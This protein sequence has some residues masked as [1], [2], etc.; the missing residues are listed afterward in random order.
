MD[1]WRTDPNA[2][3]ERNK[4]LVELALEAAR[5]IGPP[6]G[7]NQRTPLTANQ[8]RQ[9]VLPLTTPL[10]IDFMNARDRCMVVISY[11]LALRGSE[12]TE[13]LT[14]DVQQKTYVTTDGKVETGIE[15][16]LRKS[17]TNQ[18][19]IP[20]NV[21]LAPHRGD[22]T[23]CP[24]FWTKM[25][26]FHRDRSS[27]VYFHRTPNAKELEEKRGN[28]PD[29]WKL[30]AS[31]MRFT[32][33]RLATHAGLN[34]PN[35]GAHSL[36][37]GAATAAFEAGAQPDE[38][39]MLGEMEERRISNVPEARPNEQSSRSALALQIRDKRRTL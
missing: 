17:K 8:I 24:V 31:H 19:S 37:A 39:K 10:P 13:L 33:K 25:Y 1:T 16:T 3:A 2:K 4:P 34:I 9:M 23:L 22:T 5:K 36:R 15:I 28:R 29:P 11:L 27:P 38:I 14:S 26:D 32:V 18:Q 35:L 7:A 21:W 12:T 6:P 20:H 30:S